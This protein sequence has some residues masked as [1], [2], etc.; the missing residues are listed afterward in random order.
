MADLR[1]E[2]TNWFEKRKSNVNR[3][4]QNSEGGPESSG[5]VLTKPL[6]GGSAPEGPI[7]MISQGQELTSDLDEK[8]L[9]D[10]GFK[11]MQLVFVSIGMA[12][13]NRGRRNLGGV[14]MG[15]EPTSSLPPPPRSRL[16]ILLLLRTEHFEQLFTLM[17]QLGA[18]KA[19]NRSGVSFL[20]KQL[21][22]S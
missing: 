2:V 13:P 22:Y 15:L 14:D 4:T 7:R 21:C 17:Q 3:S 9:S 11:D 12:R 18:L 8:S 1:A 5:S 16:P 6:Y 10:M 19:V 20:L